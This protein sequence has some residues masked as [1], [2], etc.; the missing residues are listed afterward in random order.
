MSFLDLDEGALEVSA[1]QTLEDIMD[2]NQIGFYGF[3]LRKIMLEALRAF[4][5]K[6]PDLRFKN[7]RISPLVYGD[8]VNILFIDAKDKTIYEHEIRSYT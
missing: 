1:E 8:A 4:K 2:K 6:Y 7:V 3:S 5:K